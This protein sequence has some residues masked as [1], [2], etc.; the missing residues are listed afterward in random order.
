MLYKRENYPDKIAG[1][2]THVPIALLMGARQVGKTSL[3]QSFR[4]SLPKETPARFLNGQDTEISELFQKLSVVEQYLKVY[5]HPRLAGFVFIDEF[6]FIP[7][8]STMLKLLTDKYPGLRILCSGS[9]SLDI[10]KKLEESLAGRV[11]MIEVLPLSFS[12]YLVFADENLARLYAALDLDTESSALTAPLE[13]ILAEYLVYGGLP[14]TA[15]TKNREEKIELLNDI[16]QT[17]LLKDI[18]NYIAQGNITGFNRM[19]RLLA[20]QTGNLLNVNEISREC[21]LPYK[22]CNEY[23]WILEQMGIIK[24]LEPYSANK[25]KAIV[26]MR[27]IYFCD[28]GLRNMLEKNFSSIEFRPDRGALFENYVMLELW[29]TRAAGGDLQFFR[30]SDGV[31]VDFVLSRLSG[32]AAVECKFKILEKPLSLTAFNRFCDEQEIRAR[33]IVNRSLNCSY[34]EAKFLQGFLAGKI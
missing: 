17:Y 22:V 1:A 18:R 16:Y 4:E 31:E 8:V 7:G 25:R 24:L 15:L 34:Q 32:R 20:S 10:L 30:T 19:L 2:F 6:Q 33:Y 14:R 21:G 5:L 23:L 13:T 27:K 3:M 26:K 12:E 28:L 11:R 9:S 29:R